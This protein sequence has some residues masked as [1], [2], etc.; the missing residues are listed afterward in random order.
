MPFLI[1]FSLSTIIVIILH[2]KNKLSAVPTLLSI[3]GIL[4]TLDLISIVILAFLSYFIQSE[5]Y[6]VC[7]IM[8]SVSLLAI[9]FVNMVEV[10]RRYKLSLC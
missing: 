4:F 3:L 9:F 2:L 7:T 8:L 5:L 1:V 6:Q 10:I